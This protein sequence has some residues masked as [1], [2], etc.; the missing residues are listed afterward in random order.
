[1]TESNFVI[2]NGNAVIKK[3][4]ENTINNPTETATQLWENAINGAEKIL[5]DANETVQQAWD[6]VNE[7][8]QDAWDDTNEKIDKIQE[9][10]DKSSQAEKDFFYDHPIAAIKIGKYQKGSDNI[11]T[12]A[13]EFA[14]MGYSKETN[15]ILSPEDEK[16]GTGGQNAMRHVLLQAF[17]TAEFGEEIAKQSADAHED[18]TQIDMKQTHFKSYE[19][20]DMAVDQRNN[21]IGRRIGTDNSEKS[22]LEITKEVVEQF[23]EE[24]FWIAYK[25][26]DGYEIKQVKLGEN[27][28]DGYKKA[29]ENKD[30]NARWIQNGT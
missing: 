19:E 27:K 18:N 28:Y 1:M 30:E 21:E 4:Q 8:V 13:A 17:T 6:D 20:A 3:G 2:R 24:G 25:T 12:V 5:K 23:R 15:S 22:R 9:V 10:W 16:I 14:F 29:L 11:S 7:K 26:D